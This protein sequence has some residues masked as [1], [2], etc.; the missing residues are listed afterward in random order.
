MINVNNDNNFRCILRKVVLLVFI[1]KTQTNVDRVV[2]AVTFKIN[3]NVS[4]IVGLI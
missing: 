2:T 4:I 3:I 1:R